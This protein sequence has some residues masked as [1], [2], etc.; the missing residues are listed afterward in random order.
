MGVGD[1]VQKAVGDPNMGLGR[2]ETGAGRGTH[3]LCTKG[4]QHIN[5]GS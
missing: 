4:T 1:L 5:L 3:D 2:V